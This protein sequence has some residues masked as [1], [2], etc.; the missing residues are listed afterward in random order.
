MS[1]WL[2]RLG[3]L[4]ALAG[5]GGDEAESLEFKLDRLLEEAAV[6]RVARCRCSGDAAASCE[7]EPPATAAYK[8]CVVHVLAVDLP[9]AAVFVECSYE[10]Y[11]T[12]NDCLAEAG[13][14]LAEPSGQ[15][16]DNAGTV[17]RARCVLPSALQERIDADCK[18]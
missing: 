13:H 8:R 18:R 9:S 6:N 5:C 11:K 1:A 4:G 12:E 17:E 2:C 3:L 10:A 15:A 16:C 14:C 7:R